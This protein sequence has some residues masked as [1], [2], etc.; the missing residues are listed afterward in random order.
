MRITKNE[1]KKILKEI[2]NCEIQCAKYGNGT[3]CQFKRIIK[4]DAEFSLVLNEGYLYVG[5]VGATVSR[6]KEGRREDNLVIN[7]VRVKFATMIAQT[8]TPNGL[9]FTFS[10]P[11]T[12]GIN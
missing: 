8:K 6:I 9:G 10:K 5:T 11:F 3:E 4:D 2:E 7:G 1:V 12:V